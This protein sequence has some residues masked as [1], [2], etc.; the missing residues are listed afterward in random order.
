MRFQTYTLS[1]TKTKQKEVHVPDGMENADADKPFNL[2]PKSPES[3]RLGALMLLWLL[4]LP[5]SSVGQFNELTSIRL[6]DMADEGL[7][8]TE[9][10]PLPETALATLKPNLDAHRSGKNELLTAL[11]VSIII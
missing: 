5:A 10:N 2:L 9:V 4:L 8:P 6:S 7:M 3:G 1:E 11:T